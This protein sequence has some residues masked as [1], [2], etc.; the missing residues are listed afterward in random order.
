MCGTPVIVSNDCGCGEIIEEGHFGSTINYGDV[1]DLC[2]KMNEIMTAPAGA[3]EKV[4]IGQKYIS[5]WLDW[6]KNILKYEGLYENT[7]RNGR[8][9]Y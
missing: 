7:L 4:R 8:R 6:E 9:F 3:K 1:P 2:L 5:E